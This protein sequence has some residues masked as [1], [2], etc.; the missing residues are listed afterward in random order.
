[1]SLAYPS[2]VD[3]VYTVASNP[4][5]I[6]CRLEAAAYTK[7]TGAGYVNG[8]TDET[9]SANLFWIGS[10][11]QVYGAD[12]VTSFTAPGWLRPL[13]QDHRGACYQTNGCGS[14][15]W[16]WWVAGDWQVSN[17]ISLQLSQGSNGGPSNWSSYPSQCRVSSSDSDTLDCDFV[18]YITMPA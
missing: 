11:D 10:W 5:G 3:A 8:A 1:M 6:T 15:H 4:L 7:A 17:H 2:D 13:D 14:W 16:T 18:Q 12:V 9:C